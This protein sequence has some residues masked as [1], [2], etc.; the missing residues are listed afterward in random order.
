M[1]V[2]FLPRTINK[3]SF[4][5]H[6]YLYVCTC[7]LI[8]PLREGGKQGLLSLLNSWEIKD[9]E[10]GSNSQG[11]R[12]TQGGGWQ[13]SSCFLTLSL[14]FLLILASK[15]VKNSSMILFLLSLR[16]TPAA[17]SLPF[18]SPR[19]SPA[20]QNF[21]INSVPSS[22]IL[23]SFLV[24]FYEVELGGIKQLV[25]LKNLLLPFK[26]MSNSC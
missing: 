8:N 10:K 5:Q 9:A 17:A 7:Y 15:Y 13:W 20:I 1:G 23:R 14:T 11:Y 19:F 4:P 24:L 2:S 22:I 12:A 21:S 26:M 3:P 16:F 6:L 25:S 18:P